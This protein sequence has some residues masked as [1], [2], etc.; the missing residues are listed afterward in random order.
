MKKIILAAAVGAAV[1]GAN[2]NATITTS[3]STSIAQP[4]KQ[5]TITKTPK[6]PKEN[7][8]DNARFVAE[9]KAHKLK[10]KEAKDAGKEPPRLNNYIGDCLLKIAQRMAYRPE[11]I[12]Y[13]FSD[14]MVLDSIEN[15]FSGDT[16]ILTVEYG[17]V[18]FEKICG[19]YVTIKCRDGVWRKAEI[20]EFG[21]QKVYDVGVGARNKRHK[22]IVQKVRVTENH[23]WFVDAR[24]D[25]KKKFDW[26]K[27]EITDLRVGDMLETCPFPKKMD[28]SA[29][30]HGILFGD[31]SISRTVQ[32]NEF[33]FMRLCKKDAVFEEIYNRFISLGVK[34]TY[35]PSAKGDPVFYFEGNFPFVKDI[36]FTYDPNYIAGFIYGWWLADGQKTT[37]QNYMTITTT[38]EEAAKW[39]ADHCSYAGY[40][41]LTLRI[42]QPDG[43]NG[44]ANAKPAYIITMGKDGWFRPRVKYISEVGTEETVYCAIEP[45]TGGFVLANG[46]LTGNC[47]Q[48]FDNFDPDRIG[49]RSGVVSAFGYFSQITYYAFQR[50]ILK[51]QKYRYT[52]CKILE[53]FFVSVDGD[54]LEEYNPTTNIKLTTTTNDFVTKYEDREKAKKLKR[55]EKKRK[56]ENDIS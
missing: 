41:L 3:E 18:E 14:D 5:I 17:P 56:P 38:N 12:R 50:R 6:K 23:R 27:R 52:K 33:A 54:T 30:I 11:F 26:G 48:Y 42:Q 1:L 20:R 2:A 19:Q 31:G 21:K 22:N 7:Y 44:Y 28:D 8:I 10:V 13:S 45:V 40:H 25:K 43:K 49:E 37:D 4:K 32:G 51:E 15:C 34:H 46:L 53:N 39:L 36:P 16:K 47:I 55:D 35:P 24:L 29:V 9:I